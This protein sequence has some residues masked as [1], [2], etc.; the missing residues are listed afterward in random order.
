M[1]RRHGVR[2][3]LVEEPTPITHRAAGQSPSLQATDPRAAA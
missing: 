3:L 2:D 1:L